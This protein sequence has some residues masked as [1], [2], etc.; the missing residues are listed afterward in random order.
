[1]DSPSESFRDSCLDILKFLSCSSEQKEFASKVHYDDY[2]GE[3][4][5]WWFDDLVMDSLPEGTELICQSFS[6]EERNILWNFTK[7]FDENIESENQ[8]I[9]ELLNDSK[10]QIILNSAHISLVTIDVKAT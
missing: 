2:K 10:W 1:M 8:G 7:I 5:S 4:I 3:F 6:R 9:D